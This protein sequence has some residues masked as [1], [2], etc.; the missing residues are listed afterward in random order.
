ML[1]LCS[2]RSADVINHRGRCR[3]QP[4]VLMPVHEVVRLGMQ[5]VSRERDGRA[6]PK[7]A[8]INSMHPTPPLAPGNNLLSSSCNNQP[9]FQTQTNRK[10]SEQGGSGC[11]RETQREGGVL[12][13]KET[14]DSIN[15]VIQLSVTGYINLQLWRVWMDT[16][17]KPHRPVGPPCEHENEL[18]RK[19][20]KT[21]RSGW[22]QAITAKTNISLRSSINKY[23]R[24]FSPL[25]APFIQKQTRPRHWKATT[26]PLRIFQIKGHSKLKARRRCGWRRITSLASVCLREIWLL[27][28]K[29]GRGENVSVF[30]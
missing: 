17:A 29:G 13:N 8:T 28:Q 20:G 14:L 18:G 27:S 12:Q 11:R 23:V 25:L 30:Y 10:G 9:E 19:W 2:F 15:T 21:L 6:A 22:G 26:Q 5:E 24:F 4:Q 1:I 3:R 7:V 16:T